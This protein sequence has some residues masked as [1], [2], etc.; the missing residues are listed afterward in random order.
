[1]LQTLERDYKV[2]LD[3][4]Q[5]RVD[6]NVCRVGKNSEAEGKE[7]LIID[8][9]LP[10]KYCADVELSAITDVIRLNGVNCPFELDGKTH[11]VYLERV[12]GSVALNCNTDMEIF[13]DELP[14]AIEVNQINAT[15]VL[16]IPINAKF[17]TK[18]K[19]KSNR[20]F[21]SANGKP[22]DSPV[23]PDAEHRIELTG[24]NTELLVD[25]V[26]AE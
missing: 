23:N 7:G 2:Q 8:I 26:S 24:M 11:K 6:V 10:S 21:F 20:I 18:I 17:F 1:M 3:E 15:S 4:H 5:N 12:R 25:Q 22:T 19:G 14:L 13:A 9:S 16:H